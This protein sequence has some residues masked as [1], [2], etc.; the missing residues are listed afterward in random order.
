M[1]SPTLKWN[2]LTGAGAFRPTLIPAIHS[3]HRACYAAARLFDV[4]E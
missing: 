1:R 3:G 2:S 4:V